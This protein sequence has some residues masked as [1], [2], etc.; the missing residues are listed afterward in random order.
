MKKVEDY[1][2]TLQIFS[3]WVLPLSFLEPLGHKSSSSASWP[4]LIIL[5]TVF[6]NNWFDLLFEQLTSTMSSYWM[7]I[8]PLTKH[9]PVGKKHWVLWILILSMSRA[10]ICHQLEAEWTPLFQSCIYFGVIMCALISCIDRLTVT[11][12][13]KLKRLINMTGFRHMPICNDAG[14]D[15]CVEV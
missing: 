3:G 7:F 15:D 1:K 13:A 10:V 2:P 6:V 8:D 5:H 14:R 12:G 9:S 4:L 11:T